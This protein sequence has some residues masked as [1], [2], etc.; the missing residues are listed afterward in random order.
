[1]ISI[2]CPSTT[3][4]RLCDSIRGIISPSLSAAS[5]YNVAICTFM[6]RCSSSCVLTLLIKSITTFSSW[7]IFSC[8]ITFS[9]SSTA[10][11]EEA[12]DVSWASIHCSFCWV[13]MCWA[14][15]WAANFSNACYVFCTSPPRSL[16]W[17][18]RSFPAVYTT[19]M[20][21]RAWWCCPFD[22]SRYC[23]WD[24]TAPCMPFRVAMTCWM[25]V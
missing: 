24:L 8:Y 3:S 19:A 2:T 15:A 22:M 20:S 5:F 16:T 18:A 4:R 21:L 7:R 6:L 23:A 12:A 10:V 11:W 13:S 17:S 9:S 25:A 1:M 14:C